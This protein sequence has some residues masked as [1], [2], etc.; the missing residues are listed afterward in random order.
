MRNSEEE[1]VQ[2][3]TSPG[4]RTSGKARGDSLFLEG[5]SPA[6]RIQSTSALAFRLKHSNP[7]GLLRREPAL[8]SLNLLKGFGQTP[9]WT[10]ADVSLGIS[11]VWGRQGQA[12]PTVTMAPSITSM[13]VW[14]GM[15][16]TLP[17]AGQSH[18]RR[19][20]PQQQHA[21]G[22]HTITLIS[23]KMPTTPDNFF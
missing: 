21:P 19:N 23:L 20:C 7:A 6:D 11:S 8:L 14:S 22:R 18:T 12:E 9:V 17:A 4:S 10:L 2:G 16:N 15:S 5:L 13:L 1:E 3:A